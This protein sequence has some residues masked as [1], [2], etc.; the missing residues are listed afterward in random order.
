[1]TEIVADCLETASWTTSERPASS[2]LPAEIEK[3]G[4]DVRSGNDSRKRKEK[5]REDNLRRPIV[6]EAV[7][8]EFQRVAIEVDIRNLTVLTSPRR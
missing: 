5:E 1:M 7:E 4:V 8:C 3:K 6:K 2:C